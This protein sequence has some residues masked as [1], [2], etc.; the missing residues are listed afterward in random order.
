MK[1]ERKLC[2]PHRIQRILGRLR[3][4][5]TTTGVDAQLR[6]LRRPS[7]KKAC[8]GKKLAA[9][10]NYMSD[11]PEMAKGRACVPNSDAELVRRIRRGDASAFH[12]LVDRYAQYLFG[13]AFSLVGNSADAEDILQETYAGAFRGIGSFAGRSSIKTWLTRIL[14][15]QVARHH[16]ARARRK[17]IPMDLD[18]AADDRH[19]VGSPARMADVQMDVESAMR[20]LSPAHREVIVFREF[21]GLSYAEIAEVLGVPRGTV[22][23]RLFRARRELKELLKDYLSHG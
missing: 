16:R 5:P 21:R 9:L 11:G 18:L 4:Q 3:A 14:V 12:G 20:L 23:S 13:L 6:G 22:E 19:T 8:M 7:K 2:Q 17:V 10:G 15:R 1:G